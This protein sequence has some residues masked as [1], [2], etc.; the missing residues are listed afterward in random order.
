MDLEQFE[1]RASHP[2]RKGCLILL[3]IPFTLFGMCST[4]VIGANLLGTLHEVLGEA[5]P[6]VAGGAAILVLFA[7]RKFR[8]HRRSKLPKDP[9]LKPRPQEPEET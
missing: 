5:L 3:A 6:Y 8:Q 2:F 1:R 4:M 7:I 9:P